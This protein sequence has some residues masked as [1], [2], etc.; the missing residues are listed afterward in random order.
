MHLPVLFR[1][2]FLPSIPLCLDPG[3]RTVRVEIRA[4]GRQPLLSD[5]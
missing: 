2:W 3:S 4:E 1:R 5:K